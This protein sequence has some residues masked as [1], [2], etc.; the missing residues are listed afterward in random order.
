MGRQHKRAPQIEPEMLPT[1]ALTDRFKGLGLRPLS[2][3]RASSRDGHPCIELAGAMVH[4]SWP[5]RAHMSGGGCLP[6][7]VAAGLS[8]CLVPVRFPKIE[9]D[10]RFDSPCASRLQ[11]ARSFPVFLSAREAPAP[12]L[13]P[14][15]LASA[16]SSAP[17]PRLLASVR[18]CARNLVSSLSLKP[19]VDFLGVCVKKAS[20]SKERRRKAVFS[21]ALAARHFSPRSRTLGCVVFLL[22]PRAPMCKRSS[23]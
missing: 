21:F 16:R 8:I 9:R 23:Q 7:G 22:A 14:R 5:L 13:G 1:P 4:L 3:P 19:H 15:C 20:F 12:S 6:G 2:R 10:F 17:R 18:I 11:G